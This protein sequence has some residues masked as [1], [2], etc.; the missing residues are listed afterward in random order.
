MSLHASKCRELNREFYSSVVIFQ[1][2][3][4]NTHKKTDA[5]KRFITHTMNDG[6]FPTSIQLRYVHFVRSTHIRMLNCIYH[7]QLV[8]NELYSVHSNLRLIGDK[9]I[10][11][12]W[13]RQSFVVCVECV[14]L[15]MFPLIY[16]PLSIFVCCCGCRII[17]LYDLHRLQK[18]P[19]NSYNPTDTKFNVFFSFFRFFSLQFTT[20][21][22]WH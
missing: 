12:E 9:C 2:N 14:D 21:V 17:C 4:V 22:R 3:E 16:Q 8:L 11:L 7:L 19:S 13:L 15:S 5:S 1:L 10:E 20:A 18:F 6:W